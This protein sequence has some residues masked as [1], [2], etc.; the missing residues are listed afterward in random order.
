MEYYIKFLEKITLAH[1]KDVESDKKQH[2]P[3]Y[4]LFK[5]A[6]GSNCDENSPFYSTL[7]VEEYKMYFKEKKKLCGVVTHFGRFYEII[8]C[9]EFDYVKWQ[10]LDKESFSKYGI[11]TEL[12]EKWTKYKSATTLDAGFTQDRFTARLLEHIIRISTNT[13]DDVKEFFDDFEWMDVTEIKNI[14]IPNLTCNNKDDFAFFAGTL[15]LLDKTLEWKSWEGNNG[16]VH[17][18]SINLFGCAWRSSEVDMN[19]VYTFKV[20][21]G[22]SKFKSNSCS[23][24]TFGR[25]VVIEL[26][27]MIK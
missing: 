5:W 11:T 22:T 21:Y 12:F 14:V 24:G 23:Y 19:P 9:P 26:Q 15:S 1:F 27:K 25:S 13:N 17:E 2:F 4:V 20:K 6:M 10:E 3:D 18:T 8:F 7:K 16:E